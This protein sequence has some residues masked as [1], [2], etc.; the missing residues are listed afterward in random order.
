MEESR[1]EAFTRRLAEHEA[2]YWR[3]D[4]FGCWVPPGSESWTVGETLKTLRGKLRAS[5]LDVAARMGLCQSEVSRIERGGN[6]SWRDLVRYAEA[7]ECG[8]IIRLRPRRPFEKIKADNGSW[9]R[10]H[11]LGFDRLDRKSVR[12]S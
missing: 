5:Q 7:L 3:L 1:L 8:A 4:E 2:A 6:A 12:R 10:E 11:R 9:P